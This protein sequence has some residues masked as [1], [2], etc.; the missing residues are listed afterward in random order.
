MTK[1]ARSF[2]VAFDTLAY[3]VQLADG[4]SAEE[5][6]KAAERLK[7]PNMADEEHGGK[8]LKTYIASLKEEAPKPTQPS[9]EPSST[10]A[11]GKD[12]KK[13]A[14]TSKS[15]SGKKSGNERGKK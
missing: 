1:V 8:K 14:S 2:I 15:P 4:L 6:A 3:T 12:G 13:K 9:T 5:K 11:G 10:D 7:N